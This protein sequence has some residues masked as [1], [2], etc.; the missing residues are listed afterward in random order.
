MRGV[1]PRHRRRPRPP[2]SMSDPSRRPPQ[3]AARPG[4]DPTSVI[5]VTC[6][7]R[8]AL[9][10]SVRGAPLRRPEIRRPRAQPCRYP[11]RSSLDRRERGFSAATV[12]G[13]RSRPAIAGS[14]PDPTRRCTASTTTAT[15]IRRRWV[16]RNAS[17]RMPLG[18]SRTGP[19][20]TITPTAPCL[21]PARPLRQA[22]VPP[23]S[24]RLPGLRILPG[25]PPERP[26][27][28]LR[29]CCRLRR[30]APARLG[31]SRVGLSYPATSRCNPQASAPPRPVRHR[32]HANHRAA[33]HRN[34]H[35]RRRA[36][37]L[38]W[39]DR[40]DRR[41]G[42]ARQRLTDSGLR[43]QVGPA[44]RRHDGAGEGSRGF[45]V[46]SARGAELVG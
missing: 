14:Q 17:A 28:W 35:Q 42:R 15:R 36:A 32:D 12:M 10:R 21:R 38:V 29:R 31:C 22:S 25:P 4:R 43:V 18:S 39:S 34:A 27:N 3:C 45:P 23:L 2:S 19:P 9:P 7:S 13:Y 20:P 5:E 37:A 6:P 1:Q 26:A 33:D 24:L 8:S 16:P 11:S 46:R 44:S 30:A 41:S 40:P